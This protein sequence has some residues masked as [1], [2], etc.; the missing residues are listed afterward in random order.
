MSVFLVS[1]N[2]KF[3]MKSIFVV[4]HRTAS[5]DV[6]RWAFT[7]QRAAKAFCHH[8]SDKMDDTG[9]VDDFFVVKKIPLDPSVVEA[10]KEEASR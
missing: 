7:K 5:E 9:L 6:P 1:S 10:E 8:L 4:V 2:K 3:P